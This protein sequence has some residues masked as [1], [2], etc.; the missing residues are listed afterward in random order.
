MSGFSGENENHRS[1]CLDED[2][3]EEYD[4][5]AVEVDFVQESPNHSDDDSDEDDEEFGETSPVQTTTESD[6]GY[7]PIGF[8]D[9]VPHHHVAEQQAHIQH[10]HHPVHH[11][12]KT[13]YFI[14]HGVTVANLAEEHYGWNSDI[15]CRLPD[16]WDTVLSDI[17]IDHV[18]S[19][20]NYYVEKYRLQKA[21]PTP[22]KPLPKYPEVKI[23]TDINFDE[24]EVVLASPL[25]RAL[26]TAEYLLYGDLLKDLSTRGNTTAG[27]TNNNNRF[28]LP[29]HI[30]KVSHPLL[31]ECL[32]HCSEAGRSREEL[33]HDFPDW[34]FSA[35]PTDKDQ[36]WWYEQKRTYNLEAP[37]GT[38]HRVTHN[39]P[40][41][42]VPLE[43]YEASNTLMEP[44]RV[45]EQRMDE[46]LAYLASRPE[47]VMIV[48]THWGVM[49]HLLDGNFRNCH[50][51]KFHL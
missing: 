15:V 18:Q 22:P 47:R 43:R 28:L 29:K 41:K 23:P 33:E 4:T 40:T 8:T 39:Y 5:A 36:A 17:G 13:I 38:I 51:E 37:D 12:K 32:Y 46:A 11:D 44:A 2:L 50:V 14:R 25:T 24:V 42:R 20:H 34:D 1:D 7:I 30:K 19:V 48:V 21:K 9:T 26:Q 16:L 45:F 31:R 3:L 49:A 6:V 35:L 10:P 27:D